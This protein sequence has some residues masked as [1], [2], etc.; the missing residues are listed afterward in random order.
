MKCNNDR[1]IS[2][3]SNI[4]EIIENV[5]HQRLYSYFESKNI[6]CEFQFGFQ[7]NHST[8]HAL[9]EITQKIRDASDKRIFTGRVYLDLEKAFDTANHFILLAKLNYYYLRGVAND[10]NKFF[11]YNRI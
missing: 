4:S 5:F 7:N 3:L 1:P 6:L 8:R 9:M 11:I 2:V 10:W